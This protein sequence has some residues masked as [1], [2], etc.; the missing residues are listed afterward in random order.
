MRIITWNCNGALRK[1]FKGLL[2]YNADLLV[3]QECENRR[4]H[5]T[6]NTENGLII[7]YGQETLKIKV[8]EFLRSQPLT[9]RSY[10]GLIY[11]KTIV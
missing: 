3:I 2:D 11:T 1:K 8:L 10:I 6:R 5:K 9:Y 7:I 4:K